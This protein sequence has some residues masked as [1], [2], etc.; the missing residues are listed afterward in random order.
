MG[1]A[2]SY[3]APNVVYDNRSLLR[4]SVPSRGRYGGHRS[5]LRTGASARPLYV[6]TSSILYF[7]ATGS[8]HLLLHQLTFPNLGG[9][10]KSDEVQAQRSGSSDGNIIS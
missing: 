2:D 6:G 9:G 10:E 1:S 3:I 4:V 5:C 8:T 7:R